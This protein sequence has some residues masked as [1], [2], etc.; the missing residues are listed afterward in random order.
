MNHCS[1]TVHSSTGVIT[2][3]AGC[4]LSYE[5]A[6]PTPIVLL[7]KPHACAAIAIAEEE[8]IVSNRMQV[9]QFTDSHGNLLIKTMLLPGMNEYRHDAIYQLPDVPDSH[10]LPAEMDAEPIEHLQASVL[11]YTLPSRYCESDRLTPFA[12][13]RFG[14]LARGL[15]QVRAVCEWTHRNIEYRYGS[16][17]GLLSACDIMERGYGVCRDFAHIV[18]ALCRALD[19]PARYVA[20]Y[21]PYLGVAEGDIGVDFHAYCEVFIGGAWHTF[22]ARY[23]KPH[24]GRIKIAHGMDAVD[25]AFATIY[26]NPLSARLQVWSYRIE[27]GQERIGDSIGV[28]KGSNG[29]AVECAQSGRAPADGIEDGFLALHK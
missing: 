9:E 18:I 4:A 26:G 17:D 3:R 29:A 15:E 19:L 14:H 7:V 8:M 6:R 25:A 11:R 10:G 1:K 27:P 22:D 24:T 23:N 2:V 13:Q 21:M 20:G 5:A 28:V 12:Q 16:G